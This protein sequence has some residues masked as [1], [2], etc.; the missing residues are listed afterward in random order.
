MHLLISRDVL[1]TWILF[2]SFMIVGLL[3]SL[4]LAIFAPDTRKVTK[5]ED[6]VE[7]HVDSD[8]RIILTSTKP[9]EI[10]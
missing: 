5:Y 6:H 9:L 1:L 8:E 2:G 3:L 7:D 4:I 10:D